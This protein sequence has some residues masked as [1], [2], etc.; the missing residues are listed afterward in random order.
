FCPTIFGLYWKRANSTGAIMSMAAGSASFFWFNITKTSI[1]G[2]T[3]I[4]P[5]LSIAV[6]LF[7]AGS[8]MGR[9]EDT[10]VLK[11]FDL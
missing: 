4:V 2:T 1:G 11:I 9:Q 8:L 3:A 6:V 7:I 5:A 10:E